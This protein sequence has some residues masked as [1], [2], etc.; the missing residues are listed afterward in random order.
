[1]AALRRI[2]RGRRQSSAVLVYHS[3]ARDAWDPFG[4]GVHPATFEQQLRIMQR[5]G[6]II[7]SGE[8]VERLA[9]GQSIARTITVTFDDGYVDNLTTAAPIAA[10]LGVPITVFVA[11]QPVIDGTPYWWDQLARSVLGAEQSAL[12]IGE[13]APG[14]AAPFPLGTAEERLESLQRLHLLMRRSTAAR[15]AAIL[16]EIVARLG[17]PAPPHAGR[18]MTPD[19]V[20]RLAAMPGVRIGAHTMTHPSLA[21]LDVD[22][23]RAEMTASRQ[24]LEELLGEPVGLMAYPFGKDGDVSAATREASRSA[25]YDAAFTTM[26]FPVGADADRFAIPRLTAHEWTEETFAQKLEAFV[27]PPLR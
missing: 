19:E 22:E 1:M 8:L 4:Q 21:S 2:W 10:R 9:R 16:A 18:P 6:S 25:G 7:D 27:G 11:M 20:R 5:F 17:T 24:A 15:R 14:T 26:P 13:I 12:S 3:V 23:Q